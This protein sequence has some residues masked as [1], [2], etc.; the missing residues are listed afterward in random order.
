MRSLVSR[1][2]ATQLITI[3]QKKSPD[4]DFKGGLLVGMG[5]LEYLV[6]GI[7]QV[8]MPR[9]ITA[10]G[11]GDLLMLWKAMSGCSGKLCIIDA[12]QMSHTL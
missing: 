7:I 6:V 2:C 10:T 11:K 9:W 4:Q 3:S 1:K 12:R 5:M 8:W